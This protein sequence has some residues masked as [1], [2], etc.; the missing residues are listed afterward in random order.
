MEQEVEEEDVYQGEEVQVLHSRKRSE[1]SA[2][3]SSTHVSTEPGTTAQTS[4]DSTGAALGQGC[5]LYMPVVV[6][7]QAPMVQTV[8]GG[9]AV[10]VHRRGY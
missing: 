1:E 9:S 4:G 7:R 6:Q 5:D 3:S 10:A 2:V 8:L